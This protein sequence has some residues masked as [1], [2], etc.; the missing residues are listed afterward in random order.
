MSNNPRRLFWTE[1]EIK[2]VNL[3]N[4]LP[5]WSQILDFATRGNL[6]VLGRLFWLF[7]EY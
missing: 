3:E 6:R 2:F 5:F 4:K 1:L 7:F